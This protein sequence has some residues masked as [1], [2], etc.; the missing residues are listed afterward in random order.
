MKIKIVQDVIFAHLY[1]FLRH[2]F[3]KFHCVPNYV[4]FNSCVFSFII[5]HIYAQIYLVWFPHSPLRFGS[6]KRIGGAENQTKNRFNAE[7]IEKY[8]LN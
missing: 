3:P 4:V 6:E 8:C 5:S 2:L 1:L 7:I